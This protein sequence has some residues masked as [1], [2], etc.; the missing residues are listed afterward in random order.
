M[1]DTIS[2]EEYIKFFNKSIKIYLFRDFY[3]LLDNIDY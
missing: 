1:S 2:I 3:D